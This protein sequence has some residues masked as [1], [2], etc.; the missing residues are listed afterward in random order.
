MSIFSIESVFVKVCSYLT[1]NNVFAFKAKDIQVV[2][3]VSDV[4]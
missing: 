4:L 1:K 3:S 2:P